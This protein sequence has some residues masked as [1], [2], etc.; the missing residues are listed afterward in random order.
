MGD[1]QVMAAP[2]PTPPPFWKHFTKQNVA[3]AKKLRGDEEA[4]SID[5][6]LQYLIPP[7]PP[8]DGKFT[9]FGTAVDIHAPVPSLE[10]AGIDQLYPAHPDV[11]LNPQPHL[12]SL[13]RSLL[14]SYLSL[15]GTLSQNP[16][17]HHEPAADLQT[18]F[19]NMHDLINQYRPHQARESL[20]L[21]MEDRVEK[22]REESKAIDEAN[23]K[24]AKLLH[25]IQEGAQAHTVMGDAIATEKAVE[26]DA[27]TLE[28]RARQ[29]ATWAALEREMG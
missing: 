13:A 3:R 10:S 6:E 4:E 5:P 27:E 14:T 18:I 2:F 21:L 22:M 25:G 16:E 11:R 12:I 1:S 28:R 29:Q 9:S 23:E 20:I 26:V 15:I 7:E 19:Y 24:V 8:K 17:L